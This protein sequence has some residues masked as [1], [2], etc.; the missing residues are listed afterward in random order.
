MDSLFP[1]SHWF[2]S[3]TFRVVLIVPT[4]SMNLS[5]LPLFCFWSHICPHCHH[6]IHDFLW[7]YKVRGRMVWHSAGREDSEPHWNPEHY[8]SVGRRN[9]GA[10]NTRK[11]A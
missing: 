1:S 9:S 4:P 11:P 2:L 7:N 10:L 5:E 6:N 8:P 3:M